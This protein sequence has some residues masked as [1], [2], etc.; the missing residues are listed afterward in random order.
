M[1][2][3]R[4]PVISPSPTRYVFQSISPNS[5][6]TEATFLRA[7]D[8]M[9]NWIAFPIAFF[10]GVGTRLNIIRIAIMIVSAAMPCSS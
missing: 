7:Y 2:I 4:A 1:R 10:R 5:L 9:R 8:R 6:M 3:A